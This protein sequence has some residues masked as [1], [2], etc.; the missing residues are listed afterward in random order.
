MEWQYIFILTL[1][2][3]F[4]LLILGVPVAFAFLTV[5]VI[6]VLIIWGGPEHFPRLIGSMFTSVSAFSLLPIPLFIFIGDL[7]FR[8]GLSSMFLDTTSKWIGHLP[9]RL[10]IITI[11]GGTITGALTG[12]SMGNVAMMSRV[13]LPEME[14]NKYK[15]S[16]M[17][18]PLSCT[19][20]LALMTPPSV[21]GVVFGG[22][23]FISIGKILMGILIP[24][25]MLA[26]CYLLYIIIR[27]NI[28]K[29]LAP[30]YDVETT[31]LREKLR[32][33]IRDIVPVAFIILCVTGVI[34]LGIAT[35]SEAAATG[36]LGC[37]I[38]ALVYRK[39]NYRILVD[40][41]KNT[42]STSVMIF[43]IILG[44]TAFSQTLSYSGATK[45]MVDFV[46]SL[47]LPVIGTFV[48][49][50][51]V[52]FVVGMFM[53]SMAMMM[54]IVPVFSPM[55]KAL[56]ID[57]IWYAVAMLLVLSIGPV[58]PPFGLDMFAMKS[59]A[60]SYIAMNR[61]YKAVIPF[62]FCDLVVLALIVA[63]PAIATYLPDLLSK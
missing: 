44:A 50:L 35:P 12:V 2:G 43:M 18:G 33:T 53:D 26:V 17:L 3:F 19:G 38:V 52:V 10:S 20:A 4:M 1:V 14:K 56:G 45:G 7:L 9:G 21:F 23:A 22:L 37:L 41:L 63:F 51:I 30:V 8:T 34:F 62:I 39:L 42:I 59:V 61:I 58:T 49:M 54:I 31:P 47:P 16:M 5:N 48:L 60:P 57:P 11:V 25:L 36:A 40:T 15:D 24:G 27:C 6:N 13:M 55:A 29:T 28:N 46:V 32:V